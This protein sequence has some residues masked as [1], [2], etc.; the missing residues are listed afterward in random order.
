MNIKHIVII[1]AGTMGT[2]LSVKLAASGASVTIVG[3]SGGRADTFDT[4][5]LSAARDLDVAL[6]QLKLQLL[7]DLTSVDWSSVDLII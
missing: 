3:L 4:R 6:D 7:S 5:A 2:D 1:G